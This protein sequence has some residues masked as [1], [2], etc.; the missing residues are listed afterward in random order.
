MRRKGLNSGFDGYHMTGLS[1]PPENAVA[2]GIL[3]SPNSFQT[4]GERFTIWEL[5]EMM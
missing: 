2:F 4:K 1:C 5:C 3:S